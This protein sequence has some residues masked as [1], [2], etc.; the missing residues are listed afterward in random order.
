MT[1][2]PGEPTP[3]E[4]CTLLARE[5]RTPLSTIEGYLELLA[6]GD[7]GPVTAEQREFLAVVARNAQRLS[8]VVSD[9][10][11]MAR[12][13]AGRLALAT[14]PVELLD[15]VDC[16]IGELRARIRAKEQQI[17]VDATAVSAVV[18]GDARAL[19]RVVSNLLSNA[20]KYTPR[21][22]QLRVTLTADEAGAVRLDVQDTGIGIRDEDQARLFRKFFRAALTDSEPG[23]GLGLTLVKELV[24]RMGGQVSV[25]STL[26]EGSTF[27]VVLRSADEELARPI[28]VNGS[29]MSGVTG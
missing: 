7:V 2:Q 9:W 28:C 29:A 12:L 10:Y 1:G 18:L 16:A 5:L 19:A 17:R 25:R 21:G 22:G 3:D 26:G 13:E 24:E 8:L 27:S 11:D 6:Q 4:I 23:T 20:H 14:E 15:V